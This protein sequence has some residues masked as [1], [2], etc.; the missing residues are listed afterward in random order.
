MPAGGAPLGG[1]WEVTFPAPGDLADDLGA[2]LIEEGALGVETQAPDVRLPRFDLPAVTDSGELPRSDSPEVTLLC[3]FDGSHHEADVLAMT[4]AG[5]AALGL[6]AEA[7]PLAIRRRDDTDWAERWKAFFKPLAFG[8]RLWV[9]PK[10]ERPSLPAGALPIVLEPGFA[11]GTGQHA[12]TALCL[13]LMDGLVTPEVP[14]LLD[15]GTGSGVLAVAAKHLGVRRVVATDNDPLSVTAAGEAASDNGVQ[16]EVTGDD[17]PRVA[18]QFSWVV[19][20][21]IAPVLLQLM[22]ELVGHVRPGG[23]LLLSGILAEQVPEIEAAVMS[24]GPARRVE[25]RTRGDWVALLYQVEGR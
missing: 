2:L 6:D 3:S 17:L 15:V 7:H 11:F 20:N 24:A 19:A 18:G 12:T 22:P 9:V 23:K 21:I 14:D 16:L 8:K 10:W 4:R 5:L 1:F 13:E 25:Q